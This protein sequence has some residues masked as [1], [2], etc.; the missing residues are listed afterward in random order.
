MEKKGPPEEDECNLILSERLQ[1]SHRGCHRDP[2]E[3]KG[4]LKGEARREE[5][6]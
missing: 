1:V 4:E 5:E 2:D 6:R 3:P